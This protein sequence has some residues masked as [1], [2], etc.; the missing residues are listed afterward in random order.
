MSLEKRIFCRKVVPPDESLYNRLGVRPVCLHAGTPNR[1][2]SLQT[3]MMISATQSG[4]AT[5][6]R[7][8]S[9]WRST[10]EELRERAEI[11]KLIQLRDEVLAGRYQRLK[12][13]S[14]PAAK[15]PEKVHLPSPS[16]SSSANGIESKSRSIE[17]TITTSQ[18]QVFRTVEILP[19]P[20]NSVPHQT[21][22]SVNPA[23][24]PSGRPLAT[25]IDNVLLE[26]SPTVV[27]AEAEIK[28]KRLEQQL[29]RKAEQRD[30]E[31]KADN[32]S[33][34][35]PV[36]NAR[37]I[38]Q[39]VLK[40]T[41]SF[42][43]EALNA[44]S[45]TDS[46]LNTAKERP[47]TK[48]NEADDGDSSR[49][50][51]T[52][53]YYSSKAG[54][55]SADEVDEEHV[56]VIRPTEIEEAG[57]Q[58]PTSEEE[59]NS[60]TSK[61]KSGGKKTEGEGNE[62]MTPSQKRRQRKRQKM[63]GLDDNDYI[64]S[65]ADDSADS[66][67]SSENYS[68]RNDNVHGDSIPP[69]QQSSTGGPDNEKSRGGIMQLEDDV[70]DYEPPDPYGSQP[71]NG[72]DLGRNG[73]AIKT[74][75]QSPKFRVTN[76]ISSPAA[77][78][79]SRVSPL[80]MS[81]V[82]QVVQVLSQSLNTSAQVYEQN[83][84]S[85]MLSSGQGTR[86]EDNGHPAQNN[87]KDI[88]IGIQNVPMSNEGAIEIRKDTWKENKQAK[89]KQ[90]ERVV[91]RE[92][93]NGHQS[94][95]DDDGNTTKNPRKGRQVSPGANI[96]A[97]PISPPTPHIAEGLRPEKRRKRPVA[98]QTLGVRDEV[99][100][101]WLDGPISPRQARVPESQ[102]P[103]LRR[104]AS[105]HN[106]KRQ[107]SPRGYSNRMSPPRP[108]PITA[109]SRSYFDITEE[110]RPPRFVNYSAQRLL[111]RSR[112]PPSHGRYASREFD[113]G[114]R[115]SFADPQQE[116]VLMGP[117]SLSG[118]QQMFQDEEGRRYYLA[119]P[120]EVNPLRQSIIPPPSRNINPEYYYERA[121]T[122]EHPLQH[123]IAP[124]HGPQRIYESDQAERVPS[125]PAPRRAI[126]PAEPS[127][128]DFRA[129]RE[130]DYHSHTREE[131][132]RDLPHLYAEPRTTQMY[133]RPEDR[134]VRFGSVRP[135]RFSSVRPE[136]IETPER[137]SSARPERLNSVR[138]GIPPPL[139]EKYA[140]RMQSIR[141]EELYSREL[142]GRRS[143]RPDGIRPEYLPPHH[144]IRESVRPERV[145]VRPEYLPPKYVTRH[146]SVQP[147]E[148]RRV[149]SASGYPLV[150]ERFV[151]EAPQPRPAG[152]ERYLTEAPQHVRSSYGGNSAGYVE[153]SPREAH[154]REVRQEY[155]AAQSREAHERE[156][157]E[158]FEATQDRPTYQRY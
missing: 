15:V 52:D 7:V 116:P 99:R 66:E 146:F 26:V 147:E 57:T 39:K 98:E 70:S 151:T 106:A 152:V 35:I 113:Q 38:L 55:T 97:E 136:T 9:P 42:H 145:G 60:F 142:P 32:I 11:N 4:A 94:Y 43:D 153:I 2:C 63:T 117:P 88:N 108:L 53:S 22:P 124:S 85:P 111:S 69:Y 143:A 18:P 140:P 87:A 49:S 41:D 90:L 84:N 62:T 47:S 137:L 154:E 34:D 75:V 119:P 24:T 114:G 72:K 61:K 31:L 134:N 150:G 3:V 29:K 122:H 100:A 83:Q 6:G 68:K 73:D 81:R 10:E 109:P 89:R 58:E 104:G 51:Q 95:K 27:K 141:P 133:D 120:R 78:Q 44:S 56:E 139:P 105:I 28:R 21:T 40:P 156:A 76:H 123:I 93:G 45:K 149:T 132:A 12:N 125:Y 17:A 103:D 79:P 115:G 5:A 128:T 33:H 130:R 129:Y 127:P 46:H 30:P 77:P 64:L 8:M 1:F 91:R 138:P 144:T 36:F 112:S 16:S 131:L 25:Q 157:G 23:N 102:D 14:K 74:T 135:E 126:E 13:S 110:D 158:A 86:S 37:A 48:R 101:S 82:P 54:W 59:Y 148:V 71:G 92:F 20:E 50:I 121:I 107:Y 155:L 80:A 19:H 67:N 65:R 118:P 96:K